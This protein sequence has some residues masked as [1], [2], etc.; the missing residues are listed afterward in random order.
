MPIYKCVAI[1]F[2]FSSLKKSL[3]SLNIANRPGIGERGPQATTTFSSI[4]PNQT[5]MSALPTPC[6]SV[7]RKSLNYCNIKI[8][9]MYYNILQGFFLRINLSPYLCLCY[10]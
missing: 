9:F 8:I 7:L 6:D 10:K 4:K 3:K 2:S 1:F 5:K